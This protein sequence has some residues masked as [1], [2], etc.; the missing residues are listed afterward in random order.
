MPTISRLAKIA[1]LQS[2]RRQDLCVVLEDIHDPHNAAAILRTCEAFGIQ[3]IYYIFEQEK[4]YNPAKIGKSSSSSANK[5]LTFHTF[6]ST[7]N[8][9]TQLKTQGFHLVSTLLDPK[10]QNIYELNFQD[11]PKIAL[12]FGNEHRGLSPTAIAHTDT[13]L[14]IPML[15]MVQSLNVSVT[16]GICIF[17]AS[18]Q[19]NLHRIAKSGNISPDGQTQK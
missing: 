15:G 12:L 1:R 2:L 7:A 13:K 5:W 6:H 4:S 10:S 17:E 3:H 14:Y 8:C 18:R 9:L 11:H 16:A 19:L